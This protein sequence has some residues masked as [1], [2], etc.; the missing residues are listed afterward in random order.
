MDLYSPIS[1]YSSAR[2][3][4]GHSMSLAEFLASGK[5][6]AAQIT[7]YRT[8]K[9]SF[10]ELIEEREALMCDSKKCLSVIDN[11]YNPLLPVPQSYN[12]AVSA[13]KADAIRIEELDQQIKSVKQQAEHVKRSLPCAT[14]SGLFQPTRKEENLVQ[15]S[16][17]MCIDLD[18]H[19]NTRTSDNKVSVH[20]Q[21]LDNLFDVLR[22]LPWVLYAAHSVGGRGYFVLIP[23]G[24][25]DEQHTHQWYFECLQIEFEQ[26]GLVIDPACSDPTRLRFLSYDKHPYRNAMAV[27]YLGRAGFLG[28]ARQ[29]AM[30]EEQ[31]IREA[32]QRQ[33]DALA[34]N[35]DNQL[36]DAIRCVE[37]IEA[38]SLDI[39]EDYKQCLSIGMSLYSLGSEGLDLWVRICRYRSSSHAQFHT[40]H[41]LEQKWRTFGGS[42]SKSLTPKTFFQI[43]KSKGIV[44]WPSRN[45]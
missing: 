32:R 17:F 19:V 10:E 31:R 14:I 9:L 44:A 42:S 41:E 34:G 16:G 43:C 35:I 7:T 5:D 6:Y 1:V 36:R 11:G 37:Q 22:D 39:T 24:P 23:I 8:L 13:L 2:D 20:S 33:R 25:I 40:Y 29:R 26:Y 3:N 30:E 28:R 15:H 12:D 27:P 18:D 21:C 38:S 4:R 45:P